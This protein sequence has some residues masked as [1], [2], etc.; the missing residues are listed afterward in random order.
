MKFRLFCFLLLFL[1]P[2]YV[3]FGKESSLPFVSGE[4]LHYKIKWGLIPVGRATMEVAPSEEVN[5]TLCHKFV[6]SVRTNE[7]ADAFYK[8]RTRAESYLAPNF[9]RSLLYKKTQQEGKTERDVVVRFDYDQDLAFYS[10]YG[11]IEREIPIRPVS[12]DPLSIAYIFRLGEIKTGIKRSF[13]TCDG[14]VLQD[15]VVAVQE[16]EKLRV[17]A[18]KF[19]VFEATPALKNL[20]GVFKKSPRGVLRIWYS[21]DDRRLPVKMASEVAIGSFT[22]RLEKIERSQQS[23]P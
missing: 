20:R 2:Y 8:V 21:T 10:N 11:K 15:V 17:A 12:F 7:F 1:T 16:K 19:E 22:A 6:L 3:S 9:R 4:R 5:G 13:P 23:K 14:R 18:G